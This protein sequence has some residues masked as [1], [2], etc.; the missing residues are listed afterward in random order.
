[1]RA[2]RPACRKAS[3]PYGQLAVRPYCQALPLPTKCGPSVFCRV[4]FRNAA[5]VRSRRAGERA[6]GGCCPGL[7]KDR[8]APARVATARRH[9]RMVVHVGALRPESIRNTARRV[10]IWNQSCR[11]SL[12]CRDLLRSLARDAVRAGACGGLPAALGCCLLG[13]LRARGHRRPVCSWVQLRSSL[14]CGCAHARLQRPLWP[15]VASRLRANDVSS[16]V[17]VR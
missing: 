10:C 8:S 15:G 12:K 6:R 4:T 13:V 9:S 5:C 2:V 17:D 11:V 3:L 16:V 7:P 1:M 14:S